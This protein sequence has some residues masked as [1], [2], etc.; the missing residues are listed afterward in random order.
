MVPE[1]RLVDRQ[2]TS[3]YESLHIYIVA[4]KNENVYTSRNK[5]DLLVGDLNH[6]LKLDATTTVK[7]TEIQS[8]WDNTKFF[9]IRPKSSWEEQITDYLSNC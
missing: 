9:V 1:G 3:N 2:A 8:M 7:L 4:P 6:D 5:T